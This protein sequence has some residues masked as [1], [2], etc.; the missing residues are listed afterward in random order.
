MKRFLITSIIFLVSAIIFCS[1]IYENFSFWGQKDWDQFTMWNA[2]PHK[3]ILTYQQFPLW[4]PY[5]NGGTV[6]LAHPHAPF[7]SPFYMFVLLF[8]PIA[9]LKL[10]IPVHLFI[11]LW[12]M[13]CL[14]GFLK[15]K[16]IARYFSSFV[17]MFC[18]MFVLH[19]TEGH[20]EWLSMAFMPWYFLCFLKT[21]EHW[22]YFLGGAVFMSL[23]L[24]NGSVDVA[25]VLFVFS[26]VYMLFRA[27]QMRSL[28]PV[29][30]LASIL[31]L[32]FLLCSIKLVPM[33]DF[34]ADFP[35]TTTENSGVTPTALYHMFLDSDQEILDMMNWMQLGELGLDYDWHEYGAYIG[36]IP[37][38]LGLLGYFK[39]FRLQWPLIMTGVVT[40]IIGMG[41]GSPLNLWYLAAQTA[42]F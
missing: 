13:F 2:V 38:L 42:V 23:I 40:F 17:F 10:Q 26:G 36:I 4:N 1:P 21:I 16:Q 20:T 35:R 18:S 32:T 24:L 19:L 28:K 27:I 14:C 8:G 33:L 31:L 6:M 37:L 41:S 39:F 25:N 12:G 15:M 11:G 22:K 3:T 5:V 9:G 29:S 34:L 7:L 30:A